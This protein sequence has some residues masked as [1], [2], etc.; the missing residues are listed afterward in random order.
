[1]KSARARGGEELSTALSRLL[2][3][4]AGVTIDLG[5]LPVS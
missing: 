1:V 2:Q 3:L 5:A 4:Q